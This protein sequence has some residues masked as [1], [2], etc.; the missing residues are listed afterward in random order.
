MELFSLLGLVE[1]DQ[2]SAL[3]EPEAVVREATVSYDC[4]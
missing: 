3:W 2:G 4:W 1:L